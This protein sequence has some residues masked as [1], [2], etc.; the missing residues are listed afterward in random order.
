MRLALGRQVTMARAA[1][2]TSRRQLDRYS[3]ARLVNEQRRRVDDAS[4]RATRAVKGRLAL[5]RSRVAAHSASLAALSPLTTLSRGY[6]IASR[7]DDGAVL[8]DSA[9][10]AT[11]KQINVRLAQ[12]QLVGE[13][14]SRDVDGS[15]AAEAPR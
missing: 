15:S 11:G 2:I 4:A 1:L 6:A 8:T 14:I 9:Q 12:G 3:P 10:V 13:V 7:A 5:D